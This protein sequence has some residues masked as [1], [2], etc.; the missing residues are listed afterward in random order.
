MKRQQKSLHTSYKDTHFLH[1]NKTYKAFYSLLHLV[2]NLMK[3][4]FYYIFCSYIF[5]Y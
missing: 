4:K 5:F 1:K 2:F 3:Y